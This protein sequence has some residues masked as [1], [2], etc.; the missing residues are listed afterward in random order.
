M[1]RK[2]L[3]TLTS[4]LILITVHPLL[5]SDSRCEGAMPEG[6]VDVKEMIPSIQL[7][8]R[9]YSSHNF[10]G[11]RIDGYNAPKCLL[12]KEAAAALANVQKELEASF[13]SLKVYDCYRPQ[14]AV[15]HFVRWAKDIKDI[16]T[17]KE[18]YPTVEKPDLIKQVYIDAKSGHSR[19]SAVD[20]TIVPIPVPAQAAYQPGEELSA[21]YL[22][23]EKRFKDNSIDMGTGFDCFHELSYTA[24]GHVGKEQRKNRLLLKALMEK[25]GFRNYEKEWWHFTLMNEPFPETYFDFVIE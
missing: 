24:N 10:V 12:T 25:H 21:C 14:R 13:L 19:G 9:Y 20:I 2:S 4:F 23:A 7:D 6:F 5:L 1:N 11:G 17:K 18:F 22:P 15:D 16:K 8:I 3:L